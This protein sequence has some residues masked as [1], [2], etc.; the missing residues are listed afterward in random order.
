MQFLEQLW[1]QFFLVKIKLL[2]LQAVLL[3]N[4]VFEECLNEGGQ[5]HAFLF[6]LKVQIVD[7]SQEVVLLLH[8]H[9]DLKIDYIRNHLRRSSFLRIC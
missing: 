7:S 6:R 1:G 9:L 8:Q 3:E 2:H 4:E 5:G